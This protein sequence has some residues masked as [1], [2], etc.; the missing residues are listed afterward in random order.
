MVG[1][2]E[3]MPVIIDP[4]PAILFHRYPIAHF[5]IPAARKPVMAFSNVRSDRFRLWDH[6]RY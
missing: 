6:A 2:R 4:Y 3:R 1:L 5:G